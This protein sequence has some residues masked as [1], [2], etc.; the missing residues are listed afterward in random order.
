M[1]HLSSVESCSEADDAGGDDRYA[2]RSIG[3]TFVINERF[4]DKADWALAGFLVSNGSR[5]SLAGHVIHLISLH[6]T[7]HNY[8][9]ISLIMLCEINSLNNV[10]LVCIFISFKQKFYFR[11]FKL[12]KCS[13]WPVNWNKHDW[14]G[15]TFIA[16]HTPYAPGWSPKSQPCRPLTHSTTWSSG[17]IQIHGRC[18]R[19]LH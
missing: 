6:A 18:D 13:Y 3:L 9:P 4:G 19:M 8:R 14:W 7:I 2:G 10:P 15:I 1:K 11:V 17:S 5:K 12:L 16:T